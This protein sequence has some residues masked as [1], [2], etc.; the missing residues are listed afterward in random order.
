MC[1]TVA[2]TSVEI[3]RA[4]QQQQVAIEAAGTVPAVGRSVPSFARKGRLKVPTVP[5]RLKFSS[6]Y[7]LRLDPCLVPSFLPRS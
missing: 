6:P 3:P 7:S 5:C 4:P 2:E 1:R